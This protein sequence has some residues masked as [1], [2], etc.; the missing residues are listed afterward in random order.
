MKGI[1]KLEKRRRLESELVTRAQAIRQHCYECMGYDS[2]AAIRECASEKCWLWPWRNG[3]LEGKLRETLPTAFSGTKGG[4]GGVDPSIGPSIGQSPS[5]SKPGP[6][7]SK[8]SSTPYEV[9]NG[10]TEDKP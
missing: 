3:G 9:N 8:C 10:L 6:F 2:R 7:T 1:S 5:E 4:S